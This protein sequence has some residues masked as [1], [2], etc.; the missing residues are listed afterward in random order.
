MDLLGKQVKSRPVIYGRRVQGRVEIADG[1]TYWE[2]RQRGKKLI[3]DMHKPPEGGD[4]CEGEVAKGLTRI[5]K[6]QDEETAWDVELALIMGSNEI[7]KFVHGIRN[8][9]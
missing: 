5:D 9:E 4:I 3:R 6:T 2:A 1:P 8:G 7:E